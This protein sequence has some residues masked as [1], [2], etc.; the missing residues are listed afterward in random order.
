MRIAVC[1]DVPKYVERLKKYIERWSLGRGIQ[2]QSAAFQN[3]EEVLFGLEAEGDFSAIFLDIQLYGMHVIEEA[4]RIRE[5]NPQA[6]IVFLS[7][8]R[9][10][11]D[12]MSRL[13]PFQYIN[14]P[15]REQEIYE[16]LDKVLEEQ[17]TTFETFSFQYNRMNHNI[18]LRQVLYFVSDRRKIWIMMDNGRKLVFYGKM[19]L[20][21]KRLSEYNHFFVRIHQSYL[22]NERQI[23]SFYNS[24]IQMRDGELLSV[25]RKKRNYVRQRCMKLWQLALS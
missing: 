16:A 1:C 18:T 8:Y 15:I 20:L 5:Q 11:P 2:I 21:E 14:K 17:R 10:Y 24:Q 9:E 7:P 12:E 25:S 6:S 13:Y 19:D 3:G 4:V 22:V 23:E